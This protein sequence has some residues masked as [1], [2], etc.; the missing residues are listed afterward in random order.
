M[1]KRNRVSGFTLVEVLISIA[2]VGIIFMPLLSLFSQSVRT[3]TA[4]KNKQR[5]NNVAQQVM[6]E[7]RSYDSISA[8]AASTSATFK[9][10]KEDFGEGFSDDI[11]NEDGTFKHEKYYFVRSGLESDKKK[12]VA[13]ITV[14]AAKYDPKQAPESVNS[15]FREM[16]IIS[17]LNSE[18]SVMALEKNET[19]HILNKYQLAYKNSTNGQEV[20]LDELASNLEKNMTVYITDSSVDSSSKLEQ[21]PDGMVRVQVY[22]EYSL[23]TS[24][25]GCDKIRTDNLYNEEVPWETLNAI[26]LF[27][28]YDIYNKQNI[29]QKITV[30]LD[31]KYADH[32]NAWKKDIQ[33]NAINQG[34]YDYQGF[35][36]KEDGSKPDKYTEEEQ[37]S[38]ESGH[39]VTINS[40]F[41]VFSNFRYK[42]NGKGPFAGSE[43]KN[44]VKN[45]AVQRLANVK[46]DLYEGESVTPGMKPVVTLES[47]RGE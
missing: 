23:K 38:F 30:K 43:M 17:S 36:Q 15:D 10:T 11:T 44:L 6:E 37:K 27:Y 9:R 14:D 47:T 16:P 40:D 12:Y 2:M 26:Y 31:L 20:T 25:A 42:E 35:V 19:S 5:E 7:V 4:A 21:I 45:R 39:E 33:F 29:L 32:Q 24:Y 28:D 22:N 3:N 1:R 34:V 18:N 46:V 8:M 13:Q 41:P